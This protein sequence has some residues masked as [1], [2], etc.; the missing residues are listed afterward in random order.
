M[1]V[2]IQ[3]GGAFEMAGGAVGMVGLIGRLVGLAASCEQ[4]AVGVTHG[5]AVIRRDAAEE[6]AEGAIER[7]LDDAMQFG[8]TG[9]GVE[10][11]AGDMPFPVAQLGRGQ[12][13]L[14]PLLAV[15]EGLGLAV[16]VGDVADDAH[17]N[18]LRRAAV[19]LLSI[20]LQPAHA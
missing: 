2:T 3:F 12:C 20:D 17:Q 9:G 15:L 1:L 16:L 11:V 5:L 7:A 6:L 13:Q 19:V 8:R 14:Q 18:L 10:S 4:V